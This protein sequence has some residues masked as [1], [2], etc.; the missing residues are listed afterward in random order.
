[1]RHLLTLGCLLIS[2]GFYLVGLESASAVMFGLG[3][4][5]ELTFWGRLLGRWRG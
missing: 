5:F 2:L 4:V 3:L 1:M